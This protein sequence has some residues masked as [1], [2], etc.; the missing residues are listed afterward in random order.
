MQEEIETLKKIIEELKTQ[1]N[2]Q[3]EQLKRLKE[4]LNETSEF[5][6]VLYDSDTMLHN[7]FKAFKKNLFENY[8]IGIEEDDIEEDDIEEDDIEE[9]ENA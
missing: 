2:K 6:Y 4:D 3:D 5:V 8:N 7:E 9:D 1:Q